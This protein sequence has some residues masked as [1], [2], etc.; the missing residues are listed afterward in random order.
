MIFESFANLGMLRGPLVLCSNFRIDY[1][2]ASG[3]IQLIEENWGKN[4]IVPL[5]NSSVLRVQFFEQL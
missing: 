2:Q 5:K 4:S 3:Q 1:N